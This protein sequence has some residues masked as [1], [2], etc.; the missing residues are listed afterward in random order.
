MVPQSW[1]GNSVMPVL[2]WGWDVLVM[3]QS[4]YGAGEVLV[5]PQSWCGVLVMPQSWQGAGE[6]L[7]VPHS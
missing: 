7:V 3:S 1:H 2:V 5:M 4:R 6:V